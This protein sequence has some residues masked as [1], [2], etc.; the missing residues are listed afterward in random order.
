METLKPENLYWVLPGLVFIF[1]YNW[2]RPHNSIILSGWSYFFLLVFIYFI[3]VGAVNFVFSLELV[4]KLNIEYTRLFLQIAL[5]FGVPIVFTYKKISDKFLPLKDNFLERCIEWEK[6]NDAV[7]LS[8]K[9]NKVYV[10]Y[11]QKYPESIRLKLETQ[12]ISID[13]IMSGGR[14]EKTK[15]VDW[16]TKYPQ[17]KDNLEIIIPRSEI[18]TFGKF[19]K[20]VFEHF[21]PEV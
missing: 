15:K 12:T 19:D 6:K 9:N 7:F 13:P 16:T 4:E 21:N 10:G 18:I 3:T 2:R 8:L 11:L 1:I 20:D 17:N 14:C 5:V